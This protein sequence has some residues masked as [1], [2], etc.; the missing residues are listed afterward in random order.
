MLGNFPNAYTMAFPGNLPMFFG[1]QPPPGSDSGSPPTTSTISP[2]NPML[3][4][5]NVMDPRLQQR[6]GMFFPGVAPFLPMRPFAMLPV[7]NA[8]DLRGD[9]PINL[10][11]MPGA[12]RCTSPRERQRSPGGDRDYLDDGDL[13]HAAY[14]NGTSPVHDISSG[15]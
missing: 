8:A 2:S 14:R 5:F 10:S 12:Q 1:G 7:P 6:A 13:L 15:E 9:R 11:T 3:G 4:R